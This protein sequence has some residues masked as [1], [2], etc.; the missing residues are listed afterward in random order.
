MW[1]DQDFGSGGPVYAEAAGSVLAVGKDGILYTVNGAALGNTQLGDLA[2]G[3]AAA[4]YAKLRAPPI[5]YTYIEAV[6]GAAKSVA[7]PTEPRACRILKYADRREVIGLSPQ[8]VHA[9]ARSAEQFLRHVAPHLTG[10]RDRH[11]LFY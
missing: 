1:D 10:Q 5:L 7:F 6:I 3:A 9:L 4:N 2:P 11:R 8:I